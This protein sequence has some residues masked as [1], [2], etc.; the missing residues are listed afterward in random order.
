M[1]G[2]ELEIGN[3]FV[4][5]LPLYERDD[6]YKSLAR[7]YLPYYGDDIRKERLE[8]TR[9]EFED[10][11]KKAKW[12]AER[13]LLFNAL[14]TLQ[15]SSK[16]FLQHLFIKRRVY[17]I[18]YDKWVKY[19]IVDILHEPELYKKLVEIHT[20]PKLTN[21]F[22]MAKADLLHNLMQKYGDKYQINYSKN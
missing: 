1:D 7:K 19:Q 17:P 6:T 21:K 18:K 20:I 15:F 2:F 10:R 14:S 13:G 22:L 16:I 11:I 4:Y 12:L 9:K 5:C 3:D 8:A